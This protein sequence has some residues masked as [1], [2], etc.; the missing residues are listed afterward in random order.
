[1]KTHLR[2]AAVIAGALWLAGP[3]PA[4]AA[5]IKVLTAGAYK[6]VVLALVPDFENQTGHKVTVDNGTTGQLKKRI[7]GG[8]AFDLLVITPAVVNELIAS[9]KIAAGSQKK[10]ASVGHQHRRQV[11]A[12]AAGGQIGR[13]YRS[14]QRRIERHLYRQIAGAARNRRS[15]TAEGKTQERRS[16]GRPHRQRRG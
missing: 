3:A 10:L 9:G 7:E 8:E 4:G 12:G 14:G 6:Q 16:C 15:N 11:Q 5:E 13:L 1:M 2:R